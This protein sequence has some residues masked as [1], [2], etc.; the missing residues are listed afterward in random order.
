[1]AGNLPAM[2]GLLS[3]GVTMPVSDSLAVWI[4]AIVL[5]LIWLTGID[6]LH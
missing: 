2:C 3:G 6:V 4:I 5:V 1:M